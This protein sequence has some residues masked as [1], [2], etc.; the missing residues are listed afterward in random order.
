[1]NPAYRSSNKDWPELDFRQGSDT[2]ASLHLWTQ[3]VGKIRLML[4][5]WTNHSWHVPLY[6]TARGMHTSPIPYRDRSFDISIDFI[7]HRLMI[8]TT[9]GS[10][11]Q[12]LLEARSVADFYDEVMATLKTVGIDINI[13]TMPSEI[14]DAIP[15]EQDTVHQAYDPDYANRFWRALVQVDRVF[16]EFR[17]RFIGKCSP[18]H[19]FWGSFDLAVTRFSG[20]EA[21]PHPGGVPNF[22]DWV[23]REAYSHEVSSAGFWPGGAGVEYAAFY[24]YAYPAPDGFSEYGIQPDAAAWSKELGEFLLPYDDVRR[25]ESPDEVLLDFLQSSYEAAAD[26]A[27]WDRAAL[28]RDLGKP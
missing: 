23:A 25:A 2:I 6:I 26:L 17:A 20:R 10:Q 13:Y 18:V 4:T 7:D 8:E 12:L 24:A 16:K 19:F 15:F 22:P 28:E 14:P 11:A 3:V 5:P 1:M 9:D 21:P 27:R